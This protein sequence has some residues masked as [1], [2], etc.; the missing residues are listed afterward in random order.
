MSLRAKTPEE[1]VKLIEQVI[2]ELDD[3]KEVS[4]YAFDDDQGNNQDNNDQSSDRASDFQNSRDIYPLSTFWWGII[5]RLFHV[6]NDLLDLLGGKS[7]HNLCTDHRSCDAN[8]VFLAKI[9]PP[10]L[11]Y[12]L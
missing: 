5:K 4:G 10:R 3:I 8:L 12:L 9:C 11:H 7:S 2:D 6:F 1:Y